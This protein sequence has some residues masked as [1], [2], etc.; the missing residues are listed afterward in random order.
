MNRNAYVLFYRRR[1]VFVPLPATLPSPVK[2]EVEDPVDPFESRECNSGSDSE[3]PIVT[4][5][6]DNKLSDS[7]TYVGYDTVD[8]KSSYTVLPAADPAHTTFTDMD[9][10]D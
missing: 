8:N 5:M 3:E 6:I 9:A 1:N 7:C 2:E 10:V 4:T